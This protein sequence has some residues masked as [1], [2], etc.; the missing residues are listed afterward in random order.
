MFHLDLR[1]P[2]EMGRVNCPNNR[3]S[4]RS[5]TECHNCDQKCIGLGASRLA[6]ESWLWHLMNID[7]FIFFALVF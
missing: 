4:S 7:S 6:F 3:I 1:K 5:S 2:E